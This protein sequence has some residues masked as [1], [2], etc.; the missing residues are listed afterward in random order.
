[1]CVFRRLFEPIADRHE[2]DI[3]DLVIT[4]DKVLLEPN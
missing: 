2:R 1:M 4:E 3:D